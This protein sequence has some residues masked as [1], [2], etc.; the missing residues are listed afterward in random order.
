MKNRTARA[1]ASLFGCGILAAA[2]WFGPWHH[3]HD[4]DGDAWRHR[5]AASATARPRPK[6][7]PA[8]TPTVQPTQTQPAAGNGH[9]LPAALSSEHLVTSW[10]PATLASAPWSTPANHPGNCPGNT[11][12]SISLVNGTAELRTSGAANDCESLQSPGLLPTKPGTSYEAVIDF[13][14]FHDWPA[15]WM[16]GSN[17]PQQGEI[18]AVEGGP[19]T[20]YVTWHQEG[21]QTVGPDAW[22]DV[23]V[24][25]AGT[26]RDIQ[27]GTW[28]T[29]DISFTA[30]G[31]DVYYQGQL[32]VHVP[33]TVT[34]GGTD[35]MYLTVSEGSCAADGQNVCNGG[36][37][38]AGTV[39]VRSLAEFSG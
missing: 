30:T 18:D 10:T 20:S 13:S 15:F 37:S 36:S 17:W 39:Q 21:N 12:G 19:G 16:Y 2:S 3:H 31:V 26:S 38:P 9:P 34:T 4:G 11:P 5:P 1:S 23:Q 32:Y 6:P 7:T 14:S 22:D 25:Y 35:P 33:E 29:V 28:A 24:P 8:Q 27:P